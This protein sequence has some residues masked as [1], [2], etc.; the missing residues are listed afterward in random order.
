MKQYIQVMLEAASD[1][2]KLSFE[3][4]PIQSPEDPE[5]YPFS[6]FTLSGP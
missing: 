3:W 4:H 5:R 6:F 1:R 2:A